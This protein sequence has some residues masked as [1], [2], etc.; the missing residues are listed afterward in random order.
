MWGTPIP[1]FTQICQE[2]W[3]ARAEIQGSLNMITA[4]K[5]L[6]ENEYAVRQGRDVD[7]RAS[8]QTANTLKVTT[9]TKYKHTGTV[10]FVHAMKA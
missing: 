8:S 5:K 9:P 7:K 6:A 3:K 4:V 10:V 1:S 2:I